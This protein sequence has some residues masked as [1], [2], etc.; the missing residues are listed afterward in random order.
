[1]DASLWLLTVNARVAIIHPGARLWYMQTVAPTKPTKT[2]TA[3]RNEPIQVNVRLS[4]RQVE[5]LDEWIEQANAERGWPKL[6]RTDVIRN[7]LA[8]G[9]TE[10]PAWA[11][12]T[13]AK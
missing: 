8:W 9:L 3:N 1:M 4:P 7:L 12:G 13:E 5:A 10:R 6:T 11:T 2:R